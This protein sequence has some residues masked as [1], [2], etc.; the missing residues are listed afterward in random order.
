M[1]SPQDESLYLETIH[2]FLSLY[3]HLRKYSRRMHDEGI[4]GRKIATLRYLFEAGP[5][6]IGQLRDYLYISH[7]TTSELV[8]HLAGKGYVTRTRSDAD[9]RVVIVELTPSG[10]GIAEQTSLGGVP[11]LRERLRMLPQDQLAVIDEAM[12]EMLQLLEVTG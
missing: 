9:N 1:H 12:T 3:R 2:K 11:L 10:R 6:T 8:A 4:S 7:S 5:V